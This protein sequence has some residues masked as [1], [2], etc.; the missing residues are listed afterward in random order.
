VLYA[1]DRPKGIALHVQVE[2]T[3]ILVV[4]LFAD[5][6]VR[7]LDFFRALIA[8]PTDIAFL[9][10]AFGSAVLYNSTTAAQ[11]RRREAAL[12]PAFFTLLAAPRTAAAAR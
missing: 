1:E 6:E 10:M 3:G 11:C 2:R 8:F 9:S 7:L 4:K 5:Q 12:Q